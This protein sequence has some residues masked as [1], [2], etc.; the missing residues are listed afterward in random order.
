LGTTIYARGRWQKWARVATPLG[1]AARAWPMPPGGVGLWLLPLLSPSGY[2]RLLIK[3]EFLG[4]FLELL[5]VKYHFHEV[6]QRARWHG[7][8]SFDGI[9]APV[10]NKSRCQLSVL[11]IPKDGVATCVW[12]NILSYLPPTFWFILCCPNLSRTLFIVT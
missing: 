3:Y 12:A 11:A 4:I 5:I 1:G 9:I 2:F 10:C 8:C 6:D 7:W